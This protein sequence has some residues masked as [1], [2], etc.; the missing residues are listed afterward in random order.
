MYVRLGLAI[1]LPFLALALQWMLWP[2]LSPFVWFLF[3]PTVFLS[4]RIGGIWG[5][6]SSTLLSAGIVWYFFIPPQFSWRMDNPNNMYSIALFLIMGYLFSDTHERLRL[7]KQNT[8]IK[9]NEI[10]SRFESTFEQAAVGIA[11]VSLKGKWLQVNRKLCEI[12]G[13]TKNELVALTFQNIT[14]PDDLNTDLDYV[15]QLL[16]G[17]ISSYSMEKRYLHKNGALVWINLTVSLVRKADKT[18]NYFISVIEDIHTRK[19][20]E[21]SLRSS[22]QRYR[23]LFENTLEGIAHCKMVYEEGKP[24]NFIY[25]DVNSAFEKLTGLIN[26]IGK[27]VSEVIPGIQQSNPELFEIYGRVAAGGVPEKFETFVSDLKIWFSLSVYQTEDNCFVAIFENVTERK[28]AEEKIKQLNVNLEQR[29]AER[30]AELTAANQ[31]LD[32]FAYAVSHD[33]RGPL[34]AMS[35]FSMAIIEDYGNQLQ[36]EAKIYLDQI[37]IASRKMAELIDGI[38]ALSR[39]TRGELHHDSIDISALATGLL[40]ELKHGDPERKIEWHVE[41]NLRAKGDA[42]M[43]EAVFRNLLSNAW[44]YTGKTDTP[45]IR[46]IANEVEG[47][48]GFCV[49]DNGAGFDMAHTKQ[50]FKPF[51]RLHRQDEFPGLGIGLA[52]VQR[53][54]HRHG[55]KI[56]AD[57][58]LGAGATFCFT[59]STNSS[60]ENP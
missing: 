38:L 21:D 41:Q 44:K 58:K 17:E 6:L 3:F 36:G 25:L 59:L 15:R 9:L 28:Q 22:E 43:I 49:A 32:S 33:L 27:M 31:E 53:I 12:V 2:W 45:V 1:L 55:G 5:G 42:R 14:H 35:G 34:R 11:L 48:Q 37:E 4:A 19:Q 52:T 47:Q 23:S 30:T 18:A 50:L 13:Y 40:E 39:S 10:E 7:A 57:G 29:V 24:P 56:R 54:I 26:V 51:Q 16:S 20:I 46:V 60:E 8:E